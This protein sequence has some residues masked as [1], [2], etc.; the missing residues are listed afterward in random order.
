MY[1][2][3]AERLIGPAVATH[4]AAER[5]AESV[6]P[7][8]RAGGIVPDAPGRLVVQPDVDAAP[9]RVRHEHVGK[10]LVRA[11]PGL[12]RL[13]LGQ[14]W[15]ACRRRRDH[16]EALAGYK[17]CG[18]QYRRSLPSMRAVDARVFAVQVGVPDASV[19][20]RRMTHMAISIP[21]P[22]TLYVVAFVLGLFG[23]AGWYFR[24]PE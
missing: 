8:A 14:I 11:T 5:R 3:R 1:R 19:D 24:R 22:T 16:A 20:R 17:F 15:T 9:Q 4:S 23:S 10:A 18:A 12:R 2:G 7:R 6:A 21:D 13:P